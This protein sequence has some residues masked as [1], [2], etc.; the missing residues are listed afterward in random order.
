MTGIDTSYDSDLKLGKFAFSLDCQ[1]IF[2]NKTA[3]RKTKLLHSYDS[4]C[5]VYGLN[6]GQLKTRKYNTGLKRR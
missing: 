2:R 3:E 6:H 1:L 4:L 5:N